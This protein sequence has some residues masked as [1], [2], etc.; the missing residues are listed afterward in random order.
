MALTQIDKIIAYM[1]AN[2]KITQLEALQYCGC[3]RLASRIHDMKREGMLIETKMI[4]VKNRDGSES[5]VAEYRFKPQIQL[6]KS[7][8]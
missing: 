2:G 7:G 5:Y 6:G 1:E 4:K 8:D 3:A